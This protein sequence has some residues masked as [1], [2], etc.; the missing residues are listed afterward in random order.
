MRTDALKRIEDVRE[1]GNAQEGATRKKTYPHGIEREM[2]S[3]RTV[4]G[5]GIAVT[6]G[7][8]TTEGLSAGGGDGAVVVGELADQS[9]LAAGAARARGLSAV[10]GRLSTGE[11]AEGE[12]GGEDGGLHGGGNVCFR[13]GDKGENGHNESCQRTRGG[14]GLSPKRRKGWTVYVWGPVRLEGR[15]CACAH[16]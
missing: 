15:A 14:Y 10:A 16:A 4:G 13:K 5:A 6:G 7:H 3:K 2:R 8:A 12:D 11:G 1:T 9:N